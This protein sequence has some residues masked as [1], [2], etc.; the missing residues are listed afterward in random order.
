MGF[1]L[2][3]LGN[4]GLTPISFSAQLLLEPFPNCFTN[5]KGKTICVTSVKF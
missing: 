4:S 5:N 1:F 3:F 2:L